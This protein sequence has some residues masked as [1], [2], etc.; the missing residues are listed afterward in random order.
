[1]LPSNTIPIQWLPEVNVSSSTNNK[2]YP[3]GPTVKW[4]ASS[5]ILV[6]RYLHLNFLCINKPRMRLQKVCCSY[7]A[8]LRSLFF[9]WNLSHNS[10]MSEV[11]FIQYISFIL[12]STKLTGVMKNGKSEISRFSLTDRMRHISLIQ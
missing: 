2:K 6:T 11:Q 4:L 3:P 7:V 10:I 9:F 1:M 12:W 5:S 8:N